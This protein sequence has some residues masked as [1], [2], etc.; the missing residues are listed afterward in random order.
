MT[1]LTVTCPEEALPAARRLMEKGCKQHV[2]I[3]LGKNGALL[4]SRTSPSTY[5]EPIFVATPN[6]KAVDTAVIHFTHL[7]GHLLTE[8]I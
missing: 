1:G 3:T 7:F 5:S 8:S 4:L 6:V 2:L